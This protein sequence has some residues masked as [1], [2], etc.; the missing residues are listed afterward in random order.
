M[1]ADGDRVSRRNRKRVEWRR[2]D[3]RLVCKACGV[4]MNDIEPGMRGGEHWHP[5]WAVDPKTGKRSK[6]TCPH[7]GE[8]VVSPSHRRGSEPPSRWVAVFQLKRVRRERERTR[9]L[10]R[11][12]RATRLHA[13]EN[14]G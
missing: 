1:L 10:V 3:Y 13:E 9:K 6:S 12:L 5:T 8:R 7:A 2:W 14:D 11:K 4:V